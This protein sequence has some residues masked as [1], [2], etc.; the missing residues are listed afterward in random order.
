MTSRHSSPVPATG[1]SRL[2]RR[3]F[4]SSWWGLVGLAVVGILSHWGVLS[5]A[6]VVVEAA[7]GMRWRSMRPS[8]AA[9]KLTLS[10]LVRLVV[11][12]ELDLAAATELLAAIARSAARQLPSRRHMVAGAVPEDQ[13]LPDPAAAVALAWP[14][15]AVMLRPERAAR[16]GLTVAQP[17]QRQIPVLVEPEEHQ[18][19]NLPHLP[20]QA[21]V[22]WAAEAVVVVVARVLL[23]AI[24]Q[25]ALGALAAAGQYPV[26]L[27]AQHRPAP[28]D[29]MVPSTLLA[30]QAPAA[31]A[32]VLARRLPALA[33]TAA[34]QAGAA[35]AVAAR[36]P[37]V[38]RLPEVLAL[39]ASSL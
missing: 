9:Q 27:A 18:G 21:R 25:G 35:A 23:I 10:A 31:A 39:T 38:L 30:G 14:G 19:N 1:A 16:L 37:A 24:G 6:A 12:L 20:Q 28:Q 8:W 7:A 36:L 33:A 34:H 32:A 11:L 13:T 26:A 15:P 17:E 5:L 3:R 22:F 4:A 2:A 29:Q